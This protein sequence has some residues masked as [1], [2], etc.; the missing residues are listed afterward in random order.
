MNKLCKQNEF[1]LAKHLRKRAGQFGLIR[2]SALSSFPQIVPE[3]VLQNNISSSSGR[4][5]SIVSL[6]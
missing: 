2:L 5:C 4:F 1:F 6:T 3:E